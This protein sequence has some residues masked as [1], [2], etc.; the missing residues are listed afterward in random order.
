MHYK[1]VFLSVLVRNS[2]SKSVVTNV[3]SVG[4][5][6]ICVITLTYSE[7]AYEKYVLH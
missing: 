7:F 2:V 5:V 1:L 4:N 6:D 3:T